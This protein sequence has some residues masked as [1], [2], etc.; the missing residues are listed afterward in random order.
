MELVLLEKILTLYISEK[1]LKLK[2]AD[3]ELS[4]GQIIFHWN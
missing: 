4:S 3:I 2:K 1:K